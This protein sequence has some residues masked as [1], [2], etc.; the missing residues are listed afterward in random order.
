MILSSKIELRPATWGP[1][2]VLPTGVFWPGSTERARLGDSAT[3]RSVGGRQPQRLPTVEPADV[4]ES[5]GMALA[6]TLASTDVVVFGD[7]VHRDDVLVPERGS[8]PCILVN[9]QA[10]GLAFRGF[11]IV[12]AAPA[13]ISSKWLWLL[14]SSTSG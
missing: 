10:D 6:R 7:D 3:V 4:D 8:G 5:T 12:R 14:L 11:L 9:D 2:D 13:L 1:K